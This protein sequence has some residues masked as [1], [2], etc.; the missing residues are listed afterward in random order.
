MP[1]KFA[2]SEMKKFAEGIFN[3]KVPDAER[4]MSVFEN[5]EIDE[6]NLCVPLEYFKES[7]S[8]AERNN[9]YLKFTVEFSVKAIKECL[10]K[11][12]FSSDEITDIIFIS[13]TGISTPSPDAFIINELKLNKNIN[14]YPLWGLG[15]AGGVAGIAKAKVIT[16]SNPNALVVLV[17]SEL[18]SLTFLNDDYSKSNLVA[19]SLFSDGVAAVL[20]KGD[21]LNSPKGIDPKIEIK[22][23][24]SRI[25]Y[26]SIDVMG[27]EVTDAGLK[28]IFSRDI[29]LIVED[30][31]RPDIEIF[32]KRNDLKTDDIKNYVTH[33]G[34]IKVIEAYIKSLDIDPSFLIIQKSV[35]RKYG[36][37]SSA[38]VIYVLEQFIS[39]GFKDGFGLMTSL[40]PG[41]SSEMVLLNIQ[42]N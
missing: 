33:P 41:F 11:S 36:N 17:T 39:S 26:D 24:M 9:D 2:Q 20:I 31:L 14:R 1:Y 34:G 40:G 10:L 3:G 15:C 13:S 30:K 18:C 5:S 23:A 29:P 38:T 32:L 37:M 35:L 25:Y 8:F 22:D 16:E 21:G 12:G 6:R 19:T 42:S 7:K 28:V 4:L 27:W